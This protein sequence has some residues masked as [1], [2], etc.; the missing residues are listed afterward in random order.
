MI[1]SVELLKEQVLVAIALE[2]RRDWDSWIEGMVLV[3]CSP[4]DIAYDKNA[5][6]TLLQEL[7]FE[8]VVSNC[9]NEARRQ[10]NDEKIL[11]SHSNIGTTS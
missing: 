4:L 5:T 1:P 3:M 7:L 10:S 9:C 11:D 2:P 6:K 8:Q